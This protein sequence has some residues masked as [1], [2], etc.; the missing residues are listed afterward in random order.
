MRPMYYIRNI[1]VRN[2]SIMTKNPELIVPFIV[3]LIVSVTVNMSACPIFTAMNI[4]FMSLVRNLISTMSSKKVTTILINVGFQLTC[5]TVAGYFILLP[6][7]LW[8]LR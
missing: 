2:V 7:V 1:E 5:F 6:K 8:P 3:K 4:L